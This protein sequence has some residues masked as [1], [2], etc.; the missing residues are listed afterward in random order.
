MIGIA[1]VFGAISIF[2]ADFWVKSQA[3][4][5]SE[6]KVASIAAPQEP[7]VE[8]KTIVVA[9]AP[10]RYGMQLDRSQL[11]EI[12][13]PQ[14]SLPQGAF[15]T[16]DKLLA[17]GSRVVLSPIEVNEPV[18]LT[19]LSGPNGRATL[20]NMLSPG[21]R[22]VTIRTD[23]IAGVGGFI[24]PGDRVDVVLTRDAG[25]IQEVAKNAQGA[26]GST[27]TSE[28]V[29]SDA[30]VLSVGQGA[31]E[32]KTEPQIANSVTL[33]VTNE[34][35]QKVALARTV[36]TL[37]LSLRSAADA[38]ASSNGL[39]TISSFGGSVAASA[40]TS[41]A[42]LVNAVAKEPEE[43]KFK[44]V[45]VSRGTKVEEYKVPSKRA[46]GDVVPSKEQE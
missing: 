31:D 12:P 30:K 39:T 6:Q 34:G 44:T 21:M 36:G 27:V 46:E 8:F 16:I 43:P 5:Q 9:N 23:E 19:K 7:K 26:S 41:A 14:D 17:E 45:I 22:A 15:P 35:A 3:R 18:L 11:T 20:S 24:T 38:S 37:S 33:E 32:R 4:A 2:A 1:A 40:E 29:V 42:S 13:W 25:E 10:L 28:I